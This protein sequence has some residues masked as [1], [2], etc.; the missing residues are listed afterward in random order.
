MDTCI[1]CLED[2]KSNASKCSHCGAYQKSWLNRLHTITAVGILP[3]LLATSLG[4]FALSTDVWKRFF[5]KDEFTIISFQ[6][7]DNLVARNSGDGTVFIDHVSAKYVGGG[8]TLHQKN[9]AIGKMVAKNSFFSVEKGGGGENMVH[10]V[11]S[12]SDD[13]W[14]SMKRLTVPGISLHFLSK[15][16]TNLEAIYKINVRTFEAECEVGFRSIMGDNLVRQPS[17]CVGVFVREDT[18][19]S[20]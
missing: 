7:P 2:I 17:P 14:E 5:W 13:V 10:F 15:D 6:S 3:T 4:I 16:H 19:S 18:P 12:V 8:R 1:A 20:E 9:I 11:H